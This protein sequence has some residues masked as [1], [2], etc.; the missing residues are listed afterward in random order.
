ML[1]ANKNVHVFDNDIDGNGSAAVILVSYSQKFDDKT[2]N[3]LP[4]DIVVRNNRLGRNA[5]APAFPGGSV[6]AKALGG[7]VPPVIWDGVTTY[8]GSEPV[9]V[10]LADGPV[11]NLNLPKPGAMMEANP[12]VTATLGD[13]AIEEPKP[14]VLPAEQAKLAP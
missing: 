6:L 2:Y 12:K 3:P 9:R 5:W 8:P 4:R 10:R 13:A 11:V 14:V 7:S 1:M